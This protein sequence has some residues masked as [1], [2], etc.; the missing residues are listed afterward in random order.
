MIFSK[1]SSHLTGTITVFK[2][3]KGIVKVSEDHRTQKLLKKYK[4]E[5]LLPGIYGTIEV[6]NFTEDKKEV[7]VK[8]IENFFKDGNIIP[9][10][11]ARKILGT[12]YG[13]PGQGYITE[14]QYIQVIDFVDPELKS[15]INISN[16]TVPKL[17]EDT[18]ELEKTVNLKIRSEKFRKKIVTTQR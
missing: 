4:V 16:E 11:D 1:V 9:K 18:K 5:K 7:T 14:E 2:G 6:I 15:I 8:M 13:V 3:M 17:T 12:T 10:E